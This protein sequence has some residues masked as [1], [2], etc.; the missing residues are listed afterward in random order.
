MY[1]CTVLA[2]VPSIIAVAVSNGGPSTRC[3]GLLASVSKKSLP[4]AIAEAAVSSVAAIVP[5]LAMSAVCRFAA[6][7]VESAPMVNSPS[8]GVAD[9][10][11]R[12]VRSRVV[13]SGSVKLKVTVSPGFGLAAPRSKSSTAGEP[14]G[15]VTVE[16]AILLEAPTSLKPNTP[17]SSVIEVEA[18][19]GACDAH[20][21]EPARAE[22]GLAALADE[23]L[24]AGL[25]PVAVEDV[26]GG[27]HRDLGDAAPGKQVAAVGAGVEHAD[28]L[29][30][31]ALDVE[32]VLRL[33][34]AVQRELRQHDRGLAGLGDL[35]ELVSWFCISSSR[36]PTWVIDC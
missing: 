19:A 4:A 15:P 33:R 35:V 18:A 29:V 26:V 6:V 16:P 22:I 36:T 32:L 25:Q 13:P 1:H 24:E 28:E 5:R 7:T 27:V 17:A 12:S 30:E 8:S 20:A 21:A 11:A 23:L 3:G 9:A 34:R 14:V 31:R 10:V 2:A